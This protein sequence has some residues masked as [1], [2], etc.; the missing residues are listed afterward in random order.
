MVS[1]LAAGDYPVEIVYFENIGASSLEFF[2]APGSFSAFGA[3]VFHLVGDTANGGLPV[4][5]A[6]GQPSSPA[7]AG[8]VTT[9]VRTAMQPAGNSF[10][11][12]YTRMTFSPVDVGSLQSVVLRV[13][14]DDGYVAYL[15]GEEIA[16]RNAPTTLGWD[17][18]ATAERGDAEATLFDDVLLAPYVGLLMPTALVPAGGMTSSGTTVTVHLPGHGFNDGEVIHIS[19]AV[20]Q[21]YNGD[22]TVHVT[23]SDH[24]TYTF[25]GGSASP[26]TGT[27]TAGRN[28]VLAIQAMNRSIP[29][30][31]VT[32]LA[33]AGLTATATMPQHGFADGDVIR[34]SGVTPAQWNGDY[35]ISG[36]TDSTFQYTLVTA[37]T[38]DAGGTM[39]ASRLDL[40]M[41]M[42][43]EITDIFATSEEHFFSTPTPGDV[44][45]QS[46]WLAVADT[47]F[48]ADRGLYDNPFPLA[49]TTA[50]SGANIYYTL[51][52]TD[53]RSSAAA[54]AVTGIVVTA[55]T[56]ATATLAAGHGFVEDQLVSITGATQ[57]QFNGLFVIRNV[58]GTSFQYTVPAG[59]PPSANGTI[60]AQAVTTPV[61]VRY[62]VA[63]TISHTTTIRA[64]AFK[65]AYLATNVDTETYI[66]P[67]DVMSQPANPSGYP[68]T[69]GGVSADYA[70]DARVVYDPLYKDGIVQD[71]LSLPTMSI[72]TDAA[73]LFGP[74][75]I[76]ANP[77]AD[78]LEAPVSFEYF[79]P[80]TGEEFQIDAALRMYGGYGRNAQIQEALD[81]SDL[82]SALRAD[83]S[84]LRPVRRRGHPGVRQ[85]SSPVQLQRRLDLGRQP[86][87]VHPRPV[88]PQFAVG[89]GPAGQPRRRSST[90]TSTGCTGASTIRP[91]GRTP[92]SPP[93]ISAATRTTGTP[94]TPGIP[95]A[96]RTPPSTRP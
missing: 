59:T 93:P 89:D 36:V 15:N 69:W 12:L 25:A 44:N 1:N 81:A 51:D 76:Y 46:F 9:D 31:T 87:A 68:T 39:T 74:S 32:S 63:L 75:G 4:Y 7:F 53:P 34:I 21:N 88:R 58:T 47:K 96:P 16:R 60:M 48:S 14:Y 2:A 57:S 92:P 85:H 82:Q 62:T 95:S 13:K 61:A 19:G 70:M 8:L 40:D 5:K 30:H 3:N 10:S 54:K 29:A 23:D 71:L 72:V 66:F 26:A 43:P 86:G 24:F 49:I 52:G 79:D 91:S 45:S 37:P 56:T 20:Q 41:L 22:F 65:T 28:N 77:T 50:T 38:A 55:G 90:S 73:G 84:R 35:V 27:I 78:D 67:T 11:S 42:L 17:A 6:L 80:A 64:A 83:E 94:S 33:G 18:R